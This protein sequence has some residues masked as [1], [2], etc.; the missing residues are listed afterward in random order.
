[1]VDENCN[2]VATLGATVALVVVAAVSTPRFCL[3]AV[4]DAKLFVPVCMF[5][6]L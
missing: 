3:T 5:A 1:M 4:A 2:G 6:Q